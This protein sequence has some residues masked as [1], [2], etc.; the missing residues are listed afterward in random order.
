MSYGKEPYSRIIAFWITTNSSGCSSFIR[1]KSHFNAMAVG[2]GMEVLIIHSC[3]VTCMLCVD[4]RNG[5]PKNECRESLHFSLGMGGISKHSLSDDFE[6]QSVTPTDRLLKISVKRNKIEITTDYAGSIP[7]FYSNRGH[8]SL[9]NIEPVVTLDSK[10]SLADIS[11]PIVFQLLKFSHLIWDKTIYRHINFQKPDSLYIWDIKHRAHRESYLETIKYS[12]SRVGLS[13]RQ[14]ASELAELNRSLVVQS[15]KCSEG[16]I[17]LP[18]SSGYDSRMIAVAAAEDRA[19]RNRIETA[20]YGPKGSI[21]VYAAKSLAA[22]LKIKWQHFDLPCQY[23]QRDYLEKISSIF[24]SS[25]HV[26]GMYQLEFA[27]RYRKILDEGSITSGFM[28]GVPAGQHIAK[29]GITNGDE[30][31]VDSMENF[32]ECSSWSTNKLVMEGTRLSKDM[33]DLAEDDFRSA[34][35]KF[36]GPI[37]CR[38]VMFDIWTRQRNFI[39]YHPRTLEWFAPFLSPHMSP[40]YPSFFMSLN[41]MHLIDRRAV[42]L[43]F[44]KHYPHAA[45]VPSNSRNDKSALCGRYNTYKRVIMSLWRNR[46]L[47]CMLPYRAISRF[48][49]EPIEYNSRA[50]LNSGK[51]GVWP[52][53]DLNEEGRSFLEEFVSGATINLFLESAMKGSMDAYQ[54]LLNIQAFANGIRI[55]TEG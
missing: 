12:E 1:A 53:L 45:S 52:I 51:D 48:R 35:N 23:L 20:T 10:T 6:D 39:A 7:C 31:L 27:E 44:V 17:F 37:H 46:Q 41:R 22:K 16:P 26:H 32:A 28:T 9:S 8:L 34:F 36:D 14:V 18:L 47:S 11:S 30:L 3:G 2:G 50:L 38:S 42:E 55:V 33:L 29:L 21:E 24:G 49:D 25:L 15:L 54:R 5:I 13:D 40:E 43:M 4:G 19:L